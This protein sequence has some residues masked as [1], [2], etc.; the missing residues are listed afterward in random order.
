VL[1]RGQN[2]FGE[3]GGEVVGQEAL[4]RCFVGADGQLGQRPKKISL[5]MV[6]SALMAPAITLRPWVPQ[7]QIS[8]ASP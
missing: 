8:K 7:G 3:E 1:T 2:V 4:R 6:L 5:R